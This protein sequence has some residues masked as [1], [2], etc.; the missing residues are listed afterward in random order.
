MQ[1]AQDLETHMYWHLF[2]SRKPLAP[3]FI[4]IHYYISHLIQMQVQGF[5]IPPC[6]VHLAKLHLPHR[7]LIEPLNMWHVIKVITSELLGPFPK[8]LI[9]TEKHDSKYVCLIRF[10]WKWT[11]VKNFCII[12][13]SLVEKSRYPHLLT[14]GNVCA[15]SRLW[16]NNILLRVIN[17][18]PTLILVACC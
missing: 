14:S 13:L 16:P 18:H 5:A 2:F 11:L 3:L 10:L 12:L 17:Y 8:F 9:K 4:S 6:S 1:S 7:L 15:P